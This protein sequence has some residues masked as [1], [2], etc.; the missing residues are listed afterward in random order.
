MIEVVLNTGST[1]EQG[2]LIKGGDKF[3]DDY[4][5]EAAYC[6]LNPKDM[7]RVRRAERVK[8]ITAL[9]EVTVHTKSD[10]SVKEGE[11][12]IPR[13]PWANTIISDHTRSSGSPCYKGMTVRIESTSEKILDAE[14]LIKEYY[15]SGK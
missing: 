6:S 11:A 14:T 13:G 15:L 7:E 12:F 9:G 2:I 8:V 3:T 5:K 4:L 10:E 1:V